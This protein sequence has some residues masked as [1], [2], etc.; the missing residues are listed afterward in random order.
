MLKLIDHFFEEATEQGSQIRKSVRKVLGFV[1]SQCKAE[2][3][4]ERKA[5]IG[6]LRRDPTLTEDEIVESEHVESEQQRLQQE[7]QSFFVAERKD[8]EF[9]KTMQ[10]Y[11]NEI[12]E[13][14]RQFAAEDE[15]KAKS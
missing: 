14:D 1:D 12:N 11:E 6:F 2:F 9:E 10:G 13:I 8:E 5:V 4:N 15:A 7:I 3:V